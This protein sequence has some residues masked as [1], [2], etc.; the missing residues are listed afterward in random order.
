MRVEHPAD[1]V[2]LYPSS[3]ILRDVSFQSSVRHPCD[4][5]SVDELKTAGNKAFKEGRYA[6]ANEAYERALDTLT[7]SS[8][9]GPPSLAATLYSNIAFTLL[10]LAFPA[11][12]LRAAD[13]GLALL[14]DTPSEPLRV[15]LLYRSALALY[16]LER[17]LE[18]LSRLD[19]L[20]EADPASSD[21]T[22]LQNRCRARLVEQQSGPSAS[23]LCSLFLTTRKTLAAKDP[24]STPDIAD[25]VDTLAV[26]IRSLPGRGNGL[27]ALRPI[28]RGELLMCFKPLAWA[29]RVGSAAMRGGEG[30]LR[31]TAGLNLWTE[32]QD[33]WGIVECVNE[34]LW[35][36]GVEGKDGREWNEIGEV[37]A[38]DE[39]G[40]ARADPDDLPSR[41]EGIV[42]FNGFH[43]EDVASPSDAD[44]D[45]EVDL[46]HAPTA[47]YPR[48]PS[49]LN[50]SCVPNVSYTFLSTLFLLRARTD[51]EQGAELV[52]SYVDAAE[53]LDGRE[54]KMR[55]HGF[56]CSCELCEEE[57][58]VGIEVR[59]QRQDLIEQ[60]KA[61]GEEDVTDLGVQKRLAA[62]V[63]QLEA[64]YSSSPTPRLRP[65]LYVPLR[66]L[67][68]SFALSSPSQ[69][70][71]ESIRAELCALAA[72]GAR[73]EGEEGEEK[74]LAPP[75][76]RDMDGVLSALWVAR[77]W[78]RLG[79][80]DKSRCV[81]CILVNL[82]FSHAC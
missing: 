40:R 49:T 61:V 81:A 15:K 12:A 42:T 26:N 5:K 79:S 1:L 78:K 66:L 72:L 3:P 8:D 52:D 62:L 23:T 58:S 28:K 56:A 77:E 69:G 24:I 44:G 57:R 55:G 75:L 2:R 59:R 17:Y 39:L 33:P 53:D 29:G 51:I 80:G 34:V 16:A 43:L 21:A 65:A 6:T 20:L 31:Y 82:C 30:R 48:Y 7:S 9:P 14:A 27:V 60:A 10:R 41:I 71:L 68:Q 64:T 63:S 45:A 46:F 38:G 11:S 74:M 76:V 50:H 70:S 36:V 54:R 18:A 19:A 4:G 13:A 67:S 47:L 25:W 37:W 22:A 73:F 32:Q 35:R